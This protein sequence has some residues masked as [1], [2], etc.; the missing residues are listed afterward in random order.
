VGKDRENQRQPRWGKTKEYST[1]LNLN[2]SNLFA[3]QATV[4]STIFS[5]TDSHRFIISKTTVNH[6]LP[7]Q[8]SK[9]TTQTTANSLQSHQIPSRH[10]PTATKKT[11]NLA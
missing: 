4:I 2:W 3:V 11:F 1:D 8:P 10:F 5:S 9:R 6:N 7:I